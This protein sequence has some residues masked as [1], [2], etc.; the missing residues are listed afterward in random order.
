MLL[1]KRLEKSQNFWFLFFTSVFFFLLRLPSLFEPYWYGDEGIYQ[2]LGIGIN[3]GRI[4]YRD[5]F[6]NK[7]PFLYYLYS[8]F[9]SDQFLVRLASLIF[10]IVS[11]ILF[12]YLAKKLLD[13]KKAIY[14]STLVF[15]TA[16]GLPLIEGNIANAENFMLLFNLLAAFLVLKAIETKANMKLLFV[17]GIAISISF[18]FK[19]VAIFDLAAFSIFL[20]FYLDKDPKKLFSKVYP[21]IL[22]FLIP[23]L[24]VTLYFFVNSAF[25]FFIK[26]AFSN[27]VGYVGYGNKFI[28]PQGLLY[29][30]LAVIG[31]LVFLLY[32]KRDVI[33]KKQVFVYLW[34]FFAMFSALFAQRPYTHYVLV[35]IPALSLLL[36]ITLNKGKNFIFNIS[37]LLISL[38]LLATNFS[39]YIKTIYYYPN[40]I[41]F[42]LGNKSVYDYQRFFDRNTPN[43]YLLAAFLNANSKKT[44]NVFIWGN[45]AQVYK[46]T[47]KLPPGRYT[48]AYHINGYKD[49]FDNTLEN[50]NKIKPKFIVIMKNVYP[51]PF[52]LINYRQR[53]N[54][55]KIDIYERIY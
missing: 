16:F 47:E 31:I 45:N 55:D 46:M 23:V 44:D 11:V 24:G 26:A 3:N 27:N 38:F 10:G 41:S 6:D 12:F 35:T 19:I 51:Y 53:I 39:Y 18:L 7:P 14:I 25:A 2:A 40:Y 4:L 50:I 33:E 49:G 20:F 54:I 1:L 21:L 52:S 22:G 15:A 36:G 17:A 43:D 5:I 29:L 42:I 9:E 32:K 30:K 8:I 34:I 13:S 28:I 37:L 48:V